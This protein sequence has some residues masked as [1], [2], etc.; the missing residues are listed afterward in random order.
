MVLEDLMCSNFEL[1]N[2]KKRFDFHRAKL[3]IAKIAKLHAGSIVLYENDPSSME[4]HKMSAVDG[5]E[6]TPLT[7]FFS[8]SMQEVLETLRSIPDFQEWLSIFENY[9]IVAEEKKVF[10]RGDNDR[11]HVLNHGDLWINNIFFK[12]DEKRNPIDTML[13]RQ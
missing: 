6:M 1:A 12:Y 8:V 13:V 7:F 11:L 4:Y 10:T 5:N 2:R 9:D 3:V